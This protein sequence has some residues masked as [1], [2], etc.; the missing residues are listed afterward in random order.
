MHGE[1]ILASASPRRS[2]LLDQLGVRHRVAVAAIEESRIR[3][4]SPQAYVQRIAMDKATTVL[5]REGGAVTVLAADTIVVADGIVLGK[6]RDRRDATDM[7]Q[8][9]S[10]RS[11]EVMSAVVLLA[12]DLE[13]AAALSVSRVTFAPLNPEWIEAYCA[14]GEPMDKAGAYAI[15]GLAAL[16]I[17]HLEGSFSGVMGLPLFEAG[18]LLQAAGFALLPGAG[19]H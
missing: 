13:P 19:A 16:R 15:Q 4:E 17:S 5:A 14:T 12:R 2:A 1:L 6:P 8:R 3:G 9:L 7:L 11:H 10:G 18:E